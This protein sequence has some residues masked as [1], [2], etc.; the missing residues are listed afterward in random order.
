MQAG[1]AAVRET[2]LAQ[3]YEGAAAG[4]GCLCRIRCRGLGKEMTMWGVSADNPM[5]GARFRKDSAVW[6]EGV[7]RGR[8]PCP[9]GPVYLPP[10]SFVPSFLSS[11]K[12]TTWPPLS[13]F[14]SFLSSLNTTTW[15][16]FFSSFFSSF[17]KERVAIVLKLRKAT[18]AI[19]PLKRFIRT[20]MNVNKSVIV[21]PDLAYDRYVGST[22]RTAFET[23]DKIARAVT[24]FVQCA[25]I[26]EET[27]CTASKRI[28][29]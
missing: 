9:V 5:I 24:V 20:S 26:V 2:V 18:R 28:L 14:S 6:N 3:R 15:P 19:N 7:G 11:L 21:R 12:T 25:Q 4:V 8:S 23:T 1:H 13:F 27:Q 29:S 17:A 22:K 16:P 10:W